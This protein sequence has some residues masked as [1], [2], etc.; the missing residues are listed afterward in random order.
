[1]YDKLLVPAVVFGFILFFGCVQ[2]PP[3][4]TT[5]TEATTSSASSTTLASKVEVNFTPMQCLKYAWKTGGSSLEAAKRYLESNGVTVF[6]AMKT[7]V[8]GQEQCAVC[9]ACEVCPTDEV[10]VFKVYKKDTAR[11]KALLSM[12]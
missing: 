7:T 5:S 3:G 2:H 1:M 11:V 10:L 4:T 12:K 8:C 9:M 6:E